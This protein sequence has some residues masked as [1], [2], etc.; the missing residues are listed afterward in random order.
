MAGHCHFLLWPLFQVMLVKDDQNVE[1]LYLYIELAYLCPNYCI[2]SQVA[3]YIYMH[4][5]IQLLNYICR[6][7]QYVYPNAVF[8][9]RFI[10]KVSI[11]I[12]IYILIFEILT[13]CNRT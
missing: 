4:I 5:Y 7:F 12:Y 11:Y 10:C 3:I 13:S 2:F 6:K 1:K 8:R 9:L